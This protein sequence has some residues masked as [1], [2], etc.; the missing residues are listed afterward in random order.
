MFKLTKLSPDGY[1]GTLYL[2]DLQRSS[3]L[4]LRRLL[5]K[6]HRRCDADIFQIYLD[7]KPIT[8]MELDEMVYRQW[9]DNGII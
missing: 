6:L 3:P 1:K 8:L 4:H 9:I 5:F 7:D 2:F